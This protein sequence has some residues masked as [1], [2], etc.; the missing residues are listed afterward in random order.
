MEWLLR[1]KRRVACVGG[2]EG[3]YTEE[4]NS[5]AKIKFLETKLSNLEG[6]M[7]DGFK[8]LTIMIGNIQGN[9][10]NVNDI[11]REQEE[12]QQQ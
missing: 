11:S 4:I 5:D 9:S 6:I 8:K 1:R 7:N 3:S 2:H 12:H 10:T